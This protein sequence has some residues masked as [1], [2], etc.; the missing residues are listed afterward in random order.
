MGDETN[1][2]VSKAGS[3]GHDIF[4]ESIVE[5]VLSLG[6]MKQI[7]FSGSG[8]A[9]QRRASED[10]RIIEAKLAEMEGTST[11]LLHPT[12][13]RMRQWDIYC[14]VLLIYTAYMTPVEVVS[15][16]APSGGRLTLANSVTIAPPPAA[17][18]HGD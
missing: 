12:S 14:A 10:L 16:F 6:A 5:Q 2:G 9:N 15:S 18:V 13:D 8:K 4:D 11:F 3:A 17:G 1:H 7:N